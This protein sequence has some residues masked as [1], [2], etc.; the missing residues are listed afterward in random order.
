MA[1]TCNPCPWVRSVK[2][3]SSS[4]ASYQVWG[5]LVSKK[6]KHSSKK[7][8]RTMFLFRSL[9][10][11]SA[12][13]THT[14]NFSYTIICP[15]PFYKLTDSMQHSMQTVS[16]TLLL[17]STLNISYLPS[18]QE[19]HSLSLLYFMFSFSQRHLYMGKGPRVC[20]SGEGTDLLQANWPPVVFLCSCLRL[21]NVTNCL[22][23]LLLWFP[24]IMDRDLE[25]LI[26][27]F[28]LQNDFCNKY[29]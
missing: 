2:R 23:L 14:A 22:E 21:Y 26:K 13:L 10:F 5:Q 24:H 20:N 17:M 11:F 28:L 6:Q 27:A 8:I 16:H 3:S 7:K 25:F 19:Q 29:F 9:V 15:L 18:H 12:A 4:S 1:Q